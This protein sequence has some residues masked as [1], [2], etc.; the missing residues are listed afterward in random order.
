MAL[1]TELRFGLNVRPNDVGVNVNQGAPVVR[2]AA[3]V[4]R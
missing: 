3:A 4:V 1:L 2:N